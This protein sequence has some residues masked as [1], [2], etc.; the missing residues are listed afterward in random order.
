M[1]SQQIKTNM[2]FLG[3]ALLFLAA[4]SR[5]RAQ[6]DLIPVKA[7]L[8][9][10]AIAKLPLVIA[11]DHG[12]YKKY[13]LDV[14]L[15]MPPGEYP[16]AIEIGGNQ[17]MENPDFSV[18]GG[19]PMMVSI[20]T[21]AH[22]PKRVMLATMDC[23]VR[24]QIIGQKGIKSLEDLKGKRLGISG[25]GAMTSFVA[26]LFA[27]RMGW[28]YYQDISVLSNGHRTT[29]LQ[30]GLVDVFIADDRY[31]ATAKQAGFPILADTV[32]WKTAIAGSSVRVE[33]TWLQNPRNQ[34]AARRFLKATLEG[35]AMFHRNRED[36]LRIM[37]KYHGIKDREVAGTIYDQGK[38]MPRKPYPCY[39]GIKN[40]MELFDS[41]EM[42]KH[43]QQ[44]FFDD[45]LMKELD[46]SG[47]IDALYK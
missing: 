38:N 10:R 43:K 8:I 44:D 1:R 45:S 16:G 2:R 28:N 21:N 47:F 39:E 14:K 29:D 24:F 32:D 19:T 33:R 9:T 46:K 13:G 30:A 25:E 27:K 41:N 40:T 18:D 35:I 3:L 17:P 11:Y 5:A 34:E 42:R 23:A 20:V 36:A 6:Q 7:E 4:G 22:A 15:W 31:Y 12:L 26:R 37:A